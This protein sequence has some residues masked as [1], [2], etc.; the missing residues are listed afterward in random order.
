MA[1][2]A[3]KIVIVF[4]SFLFVSVR[5]IDLHAAIYYVRNGGNDNKDGLSDK[6]AWATINKVNKF[7]F[8]DGDTICFKRGSVFS[9]QTLRSSGNNNFTIQ[10]YGEGDKPLFNANSIRPIFIKNDIPIAN[11]RIKNIDISGSNWSASKDYALTVINING[12]I[13]EGIYGNGHGNGGQ[14][15]KSAIFIGSSKAEDACKGNIDIFNCEL[16]NYGTKPILTPGTDYCGIVI[17]RIT[18]GTI[19][20]Y[21]NIIHD[22]T[23]DCIQLFSA[24]AQTKIFNNILYNAGENSIDIKSSSNVAIISN[25]LYRENGFTGKGGSGGSS[26]VALHDPYQVSDTM[27]I[28][29]SGNAFD[30]GD[31]KYCVSIN[32]INDVKVFNN[33]FKSKSGVGIMVSRSRNIKINQNKFKDISGNIVIGHDTNRLEIYNN[34]FS[35]PN[36]K[37]INKIDGGCIYVNNGAF[38]ET[39][40]YNNTFYNNGTCLNLIAIDFSNGT[41][42]ENNI[43]YQSNANPLAFF[44]YAVSAGSP[45]ISKGNCYY[46]P[47]SDNVFYYK[48]ISFTKKNFTACPISH[49]DIFADPLFKDADSDDY[50]LQK[51]S[52]CSGKGASLTNPFLYKNRFLKKTKA[53]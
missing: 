51:E 8:S 30:G 34:I 22:I 32:S 41:V 10:D 45:P 40:I 11:L 43:V 15:G 18:N 50:S 4:F 3:T 35:N 33:F 26:I 5:I 31:Q 28:L 36:T 42:I 47:M 49:N 9:D 48:N 2:N 53:Y 13:V 37:I 6:N 27:N 44:L 1:I 17:G 24:T 39:K 20:I 46:N 52:L 7:K 29:V 19:S 38:E 21:N 16:L 25:S 14:Y 12:I 23:A